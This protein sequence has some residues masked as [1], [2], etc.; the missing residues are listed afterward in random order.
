MRRLILSVMILFSFLFSSRAQELTAKLTVNSQK[1]QIANQDI[2]ISIQEHINKLLNE[3]QWTGAT[4]HRNEKINCTAIITINEK[5]TDN[6]FNAD[7]QLSVQRPV[8]NSTYVT[9]LL[10]YK[11]T[12]LDFDYIY[13]QNLE[14]NDMSQTN[15]LVATI[16]FYAYI[17]IGLDF[18]SFSLNGGKPYFAKAL[19]IANSS[20]SLSPKG[21]E[22]FSRDKNR[23][24]LAMALTEESSKEFHTLWYNYHRLGLDEMAANPARARIRIIET[25]TELKKLQ[26]SRPQS[27]LLPL[28]AE[29]KLDELVKICSQATPEQKKEVKAML[30]KI[31]PTKT[32]I[33]NTLK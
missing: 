24:D 7:I 15:N 30:L 5:V 26:E 4:F 23:H 31:F 18:D 29:A 14:Y 17:I 22:A 9:T 1:V 8:Y 28:F 10:N 3:Q 33:I 32:Q 16:A 12:K 2:F 27:P 19:D 13:G 11:D 6:S 20:Q 21:W 25:V